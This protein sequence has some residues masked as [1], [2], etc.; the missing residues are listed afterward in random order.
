MR[1][2]LYIP[3]SPRGA[4]SHS[5]R[6][7]EEVLD[8]LRELHPAAVVRTRDLIA[9]PPDP[10]NAA[11][12]AAVLDPSASPDAFR[13][14]EMLIN[15]L[16]WADTVV[17]ATPMHNFTVPAVLK[18]WID[19]IVRIHRTFASTPEGKVGKLR[20]RP[21]FVVIASGG[22]FSGPSPTGT[23]AQPDF[24]TP[25]LRTIL[26]TIGLHDIHFLALEGAT[27]GPEMLQRAVAAAR[28]DLARVLEGT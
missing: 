19:Q 7:A 26:T 11:F 12:S 17:I 2:I 5:L 14:S 1:S 20:D 10:V 13:Q 23:P 6:F 15:E 25:Y 9:T 21:V 3:C 4:D 22:W 24:L 8:R 28:A 16:E 27:R 18:A